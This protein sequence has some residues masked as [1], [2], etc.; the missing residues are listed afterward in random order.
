MGHNWKNPPA[1]FDPDL[2]KWLAAADERGTRSAYSGFNCCPVSEEGDTGWVRVE[3]GGGVE[4][5]KYEG[6]C[7]KDKDNQPFPIEILPE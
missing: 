7:G 4:K 5:G 2:K 1:N 3:I 6:K